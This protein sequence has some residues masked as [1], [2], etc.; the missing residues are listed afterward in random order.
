MHAEDVNTCGS[1]CFALYWTLRANHS[2]QKYSCEKGC[3]NLLIGILSIHGSH[4]LLSKACC[5]TL[6]SVLSSDGL[7]SKYCTEDALNAVQECCGTHEDSEEILPLLLSLMREEDPRVKD[8]VSRNVCTNEVIPKCGDGDDC[9][10]D[11]DDYCPKCCVQQKA[12]RCFT[13]DKEVKYYCE[14][15]WRR[16]HQGHKGEEFFYPVRCS[17]K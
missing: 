1:G 8:A 10:L 9:D 6:G 3:I 4:K 17:T 2:N 16:N 11:G 15:C 12:F 7:H 5:M 13:C 14:T